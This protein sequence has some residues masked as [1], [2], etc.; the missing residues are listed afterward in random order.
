VIL[1]Q[2]VHVISGDFSK[3]GLKLKMLIANTLLFF[4]T[5]WRT[6][7]LLLV[8]NQLRPNP[9]PRVWQYGLGLGPRV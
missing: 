1:V 9:R 4:A 2:R 7:D 8:C 5:K 6:K 3:V